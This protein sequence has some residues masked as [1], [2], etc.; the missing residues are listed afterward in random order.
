MVQA[1]PP[2]SLS[3][4]RSPSSSSS[5]SSSTSSSACSSSTCSSS[6]P[7]RIHGSGGDKGGSSSSSSSSLNRNEGSQ[8]LRYLGEGV[9]TGTSSPMH[10]GHRLF[11]QQQQQQQQ[12]QRLRQFQQQQQQQQQQQRFMSAAA[13]AA[14]TAAA[15]ASSMSPLY[16]G[17]AIFGGGGQMDAFAPSTTGGGVVMPGVEAFGCP[18]ALGGGPEYTTTIPAMAA[19]AHASAF[20]SPIDAN[21]AAL[22][23]EPSAITIPGIGIGGV[24]LCG[25]SSG[26][27]G[28]MSGSSSGSDGGGQFG[29][30]GAGAGAALPPP[31]SE[32]SSCSYRSGC[33]G[34]GVWRDTL[35]LAGD[36]GGL[37]DGGGVG[38]PS[39]LGMMV[40]SGQQQRAQQSE[41]LAK[42]QQ[43]QQQQQMGHRSRQNHNVPPAVDT[44]P[45]SPSLTS[46]SSGD[47]DVAAAATPPTTGEAAERAEPSPG[48]SDDSDSGNPYDALVI[49]VDNGGDGIPLADNWMGLETIV[50]GGEL[51]AWQNKGGDEHFDFLAVFAFEDHFGML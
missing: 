38:L 15:T 1:S 47:I 46:A 36:V 9:T 39:P 34:G 18:P 23:L 31:G 41:P 3:A 27:G 24:G 11:Q 22:S 8:R 32:S 50:G 35:E 33:G 30:A 42:Q 16:G 14:A 26:F 19:A 10:D 48:P 6:P 51:E 13:A 25:Y 37:D 2:T 40:T 5:L 29:V 20:G 17:F 21:P 44:H 12:Y 49:D 43:Q 7:P 45:A 4:A 28:G